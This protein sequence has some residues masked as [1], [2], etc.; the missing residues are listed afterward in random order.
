MS[1]KSMTLQELSAGVRETVISSGE[2]EWDAFHMAFGLAE[3]AGEV[4]G[5]LKRF[6]RG[7]PGAHPADPQWLAA[8]SG[9][10]GDTLWYVAALADVLGLSLDQVAAQLLEKTRSRKARG[11]LTGSGDSR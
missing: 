11:V 8:V 6:C 10:L 2:L 1:D 5:K 7:D 3:E 9:E 4:A